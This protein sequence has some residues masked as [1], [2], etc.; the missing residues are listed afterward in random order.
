M[1]NLNYTLCNL[2]FVL[3]TKDEKLIPCAFILMTAKRRRMVVINL[4]G[5]FYV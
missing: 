2:D 1:Y 4:T 5:F 3:L